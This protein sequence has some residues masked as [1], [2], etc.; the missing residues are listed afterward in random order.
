MKKELATFSIVVVLAITVTFM[1]GCPSQTSIAALVTV[2]GNA[3]SS[4]AALEGN[5]ALAATLKTDTAAGASAVANWKSGTPSQ[6]VIS[7]LNLV[8]ADLDL[9]PVT[10]RYAPLVDLAIGTV[11][12][13]LEI[14]H[15][16]ASSIDSVHLRPGI[17]HR[18]S[19]ANPPKT[20][21]QFTKEWNDLAPAEATIK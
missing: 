9:F 14:I 16:G 13:I 1:A 4:I 19:L 7:A 11:E 5:T 3:A 6:N 21:A 10:S 18:V 15:P 8:E 12:S 20:A 2:L 17:T